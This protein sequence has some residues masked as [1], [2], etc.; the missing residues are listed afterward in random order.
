MSTLEPA[1]R[2]VLLFRRPAV[3]WLRDPVVAA[4]LLAGALHVLWAV[5]LAN[6]GGDLAAQYAWTAFADR[7]PDS[8][9][10][11]S[12]YGGMHPASYSVLTP[13]LM[14]ALG[15][16][17]TAVIAG[18]LSAGLFARLLVRAGV[19][20]PLPS[21]L[22]G[23][24]AL[25]CDSASGRVTFAIGVMFALAATV[26]GYESWGNRMVR[27]GAA[28]VLGALATLC[29]P[30]AGLFVEV[31][32]AAMFLTGRRR[33][34]C[35]MAAGPVLVV[36]ATTVFFPFYG[37][38]PFSVGG[39]LLPVL[40]AGPLALWAPRS[41]RPVRTGALVYVVGVVL[42]LAIPSPVG[43]NVSRL[44]LLFGGA[45]LLAA[46]AEPGRAGGTRRLVALCLAFAV[47]AVWQVVKPVQ[48][49]I[50]T[51]PANGWP[52]YARPLV[53]ELDRLG[54]DRGRVEVVPART[55]W[56][57]AGLAP[58][59]NLARGWNRQADVERNPL[60]Y[61]DG[62][63][64][65]AYHDWLRRWAVGY[66][67]LP[68]TE[69]DNASVA[70]AHLVEQGQPWLRQVWRDDHWR[71]FRLTDPVPMAAAPSKV[72][73]AG[74]GE[75]SVDVPAAGP[76]LV[77]VAWSPWLEVLGGR[78]CLE[79]DGEWTRLRARGAGT[80]RIGARYRL[81]RGTPCRPGPHGS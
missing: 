33:A 31:V 68:D 41:W 61:Q 25:W 74:A 65:G 70:E 36:A 72:V 58:Y 46:V 10:N 14:A 59:V 24:F 57:A 27:G 69:L 52:S 47:A 53:A 80:Y 42:T 20:R 39:A 19:R 50:A 62:L 7:N 28:A 45:L 48:D 32:A 15:V 66:V 73:R 75:L 26:A 23:A 81:P 76:V 3:R 22:W 8:A 37:V 49:L 2:A 67:V 16:R 18:T 79:Q 21:A 34:G 56:E 29:S 9:Y 54:A 63:T 55:H 13:Y 4:L 51:R 64:A 1:P 40:V 30:V 6:E 35:V 11:L 43:S 71:V 60:F 12:W 5:F 38:Q 44:A 78:G 17:T 77:R